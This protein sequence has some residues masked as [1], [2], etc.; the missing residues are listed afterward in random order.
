MD[1]GMN[2]NYEIICSC[3]GKLSD[4]N[5][6][7]GMC[8]WCHRVID[9]N[10]VQKVVVRDTEIV[11]HQRIVKNQSVNTPQ[12]VVVTQSQEGLSPDTIVLIMGFIFYMMNP[13]LGV[14]FLLGYYWPTSTREE[15]IRNTEKRR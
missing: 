9:N 2:V 15:K 13:L 11:K 7:G 6:M 10:C 5:V 8:P 3:G 4:L 14:L 12:R 1:K